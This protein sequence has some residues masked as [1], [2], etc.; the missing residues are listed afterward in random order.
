MEDESVLIDTECLLT[1]FPSSLSLRCYNFMLYKAKK[2]CL[3]LRS[4]PRKNMK[5]PSLF[6]RANELLLVSIN[7]I[8][9]RRTYTYSIPLASRLS[10]KRVIRRFPLEQTLTQ[11]TP[12]TEEK[13]RKTRRDQL[14]T[15][16]L[17]RPLEL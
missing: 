15:N 11:Y 1:R 14:P 9:V 6:S 16:S 12:G 7:N 8:D 5:L 4:R 3:C 10:I 2:S 17:Q 13:S